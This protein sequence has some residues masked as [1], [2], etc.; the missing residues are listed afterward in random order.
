MQW[1]GEGGLKPETDM[2]LREI[3]LTPHEVAGTI[4]VTDKLLRNWQAAD[5]LLRQQLRGAVVQA[6]DFA[7]PARQR[8]RQAARL[9]R[10]ARALTGCRGPPPMP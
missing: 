1:I 3:S 8:H 2:R 7:F 10:L 4:T 9:P 6:E 5:A